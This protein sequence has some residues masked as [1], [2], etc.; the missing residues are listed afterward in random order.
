MNYNKKGFTLIELMIYIAIVA[1]ILIVAT[2]FAWNVINSRTKTF[3]IQEV[4]QNGRFIIEK[5]SRSALGA[6]SITAPLVGATGSSLDLIVDD[7]PLT[8]VD[9][10]LNAESIQMSNDGGPYIDLNSNNVRVTNLDFINLSSADSRTKNI[11]I[12]F[13]LDHVNPENRQEWSYSDTFETT[14]ELRNE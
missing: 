8:T 2:S 4:E 12:R 7:A 5:I 3:V 10:I 14:I 1:G 6:Q 13:T 9:F 11:K